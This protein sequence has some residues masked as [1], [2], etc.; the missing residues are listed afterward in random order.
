MNNQII[1]LIWKTGFIAFLLVIVACSGS[2]N[3][4]ESTTERDVKEIE[5]D[6]EQ[7]IPE[8]EI[9]FPE[10]KYEVKKTENRVAQVGDRHRSRGFVACDA[11]KGHGRQGSPSE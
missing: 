4:T 11:G 8:F 3:K 7:F 1:K 6:G 5:K 9:K 10:S 2:Q